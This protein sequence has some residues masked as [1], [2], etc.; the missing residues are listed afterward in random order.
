MRT[1][2]NLTFIANFETFHGHLSCF[3]RKNVLH[4]IFGNSS[5]K[6][7]SFFVTLVK[8]KKMGIKAF[9]K[10]EINYLKQ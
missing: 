7:L 5:Q 6:C 4:N 2:L 10:N 9:K 3:I 1:K 8:I